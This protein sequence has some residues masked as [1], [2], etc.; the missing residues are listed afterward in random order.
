[1]GSWQYICYIC[2]AEELYF[3]SLLALKLLGGNNTCVPDSQILV[4][5]ISVIFFVCPCPTSACSALSLF[6]GCVPGRIR[7]YL[8]LRYLFSS[9]MFS[10]RRKPKKAPET[11][12]I[13]TSPSLPELNSQGIPWPEDLVDIAAIRH[14]PPPEELV[15][16]GAAKTSFQGSDHAAIPFH[17]PFRPSVGKPKEGSSIS[18]LYISSVP[19]SAF[20]NRKA[21][22]LSAG[23][24]S[25]R[26]A[27]I[28][29][30]FNLMVSHL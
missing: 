22:P 11:P 16:Q 3:V 14:S 21:P 20:D 13:R 15:H 30:T 4:S 18:S 25:Q 2:Q 29:P 9:I 17:K 5:R 24:Y 28:P 1:M 8:H 12:L 19:P 23:R 10:F 6:L 26:R 7:R 27:R